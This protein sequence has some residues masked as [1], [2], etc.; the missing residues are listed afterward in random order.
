VSYQVFARKYRPK[1]FQDVLGQDHVVRTLRNAI[2]GN[3]L[4]HAYLFVGPRG[5][6][7][8]STARIFAKA[9]N[10]TGGPKVEFD[11]E[12]DICLEIAD[13]SSLD[14]LEIDGASNRGI[15]EIRQLRETVQYAPARG[16]FKIYYIDE[17]HMLTK[18]AFN[19]LL[20]TLEEPPEHVKFFFATTEP[21]KILATILSRCQRFDLRPI[22]AD[23]IAKHL[24]HI[25]EQENVRL[26]PDAAW[27]IARGADGG[28]RDAQSMLDQLVAFCGE[29]IAE[30]DVLDVFGFTSR[31]TVAEL[32]A[33]LFARDT[34]AALQLVEREAKA[35]RELGQ[36]L[37]DVVD[38]LRSLLVW[39]VDPDSG[40][41]GMPVETWKQLTATAKPVPTDRILAMVDVFAE[42]E[43]RMRWATHKRLHFEIGLMKT[44]QVLGEVRL[45]D[46]IKTVAGVASAETLPPPPATAAPAKPAPAARKPDPAPE[47]KPPAAPEPAAAKPEPAPTPKEKPASVKTE[48]A[49]AAPAPA[50]PA[51]A[52][53]APPAPAEKPQARKPATGSL[54]H[55][56]DDAPD[57]PE[58]EPEPRPK[59]APKKTAP[60]KPAPETATDDEFH[61]DPLIQKCMEMFKGSFVK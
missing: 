19:A 27:A 12:E 9:L 39:K 23:L 26:D 18:E 50:A 33:A 44:V 37:A 56:I 1:T 30:A 4:A 14:V 47:T 61:N 21:E 53:P 60:E 55:L 3:R 28:M 43:A 34:P 45:S 17:V 15:D 42:T 49:P 2:S 16:R 38:T 57:E 52:E 54:E 22:P 51:P 36:L 41:D 31:E 6:G 10:C 5:T 48:P 13:G 11:P 29:T 7:K 59:P 58:P 40:G 24:T 8:T 25:A 20:K 35:G 32:L 46:V